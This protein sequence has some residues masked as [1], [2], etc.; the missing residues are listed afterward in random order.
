MR[1]Q[2]FAVLIVSLLRNIRSAAARTLRRK[3]S[4]PVIKGENAHESKYFDKSEVIARK[5]RSRNSKSKNHYYIP[6]KQR[7]YKHHLFYQPHHDTGV[8]HFISNSTIKE[9]STTTLLEVKRNDR[10]LKNGKNNR[11]R[12][13]DTRSRAGGHKTHNQER[14]NE[15]H[16]VSYIDHGPRATHGIDPSPNA[17]DWDKMTVDE[18]DYYFW[19]ILSAQSYP[20]PEEPTQ[21]PTKVPTPT[22]QPTFKPRPG[23]PVPAMV[24]N[25]VEPTR[26]RTLMPTVPLSTAPIAAPPVPI[27]SQTCEDMDRREALLMYLT[28]ITGEATLMDSSAPQARA[29]LWMLDNDP[30]QVDPCTYTGTVQRFILATL[31]FFYRWRIVEFGQWVAVGRCGMQ[32]DGNNLS[33]RF[34]VFNRI[35]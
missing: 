35:A 22:P 13:K 3:R 4:Y 18:L 31:F 14:S 23:S 16:E 28:M 25:T 32:L 30:G 29:Y 26:V 9:T 10:H 6:D 27:P 15:G 7:P 5:M 34:R 1:A 20:Q 33:R 11:A 21:T 2:W 19:E 17:I 12:K 8:L 24:M